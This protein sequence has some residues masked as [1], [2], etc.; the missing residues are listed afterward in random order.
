MVHVRISL[1][2][3]CFPSL[4]PHREAYVFGSISHEDAVAQLMKPFN[5]HGAYLVREEMMSTDQFLYV[6]DGDTVQHYTIKEDDYQS[7]ALATNDKK[8]YF[9]LKELVEHFSQNSGELCTRLRHPCPYINEWLIEGHQ[10]KL[11]VRLADDK[12]VEVWKGLWNSNKLVAVKTLKPNTVSKHVFLREFHILK[13]LKHP[14][15]VCLYAT[16]STDDSA[17]IVTEFLNH[18]NLV[19][20]Y[21]KGGSLLKMSDILSVV[22]QVLNGMTY[23]QEHNTVHLNFG[24]KKVQLTDTLCCKVC[25]FSMAKKIPVDSG[26][27]LEREGFPVKWSAPEVCFSRTVHI[28]S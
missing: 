16:F 8:T 3:M 21:R 6:R 22:K 19:Q 1:V 28:N 24:A 2:L 26:C 18:G 17:S 15:I 4:H 9:D 25:D 5:D 11:Q 12:S 7:L 23:L 20:Y 13:T 27:E 10:I 14:N